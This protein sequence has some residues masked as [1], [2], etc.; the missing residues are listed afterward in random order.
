MSFNEA[1]SGAHLHRSPL[2]QRRTKPWTRTPA[3]FLARAN[4]R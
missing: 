3:R 1:G 2:S 4:R